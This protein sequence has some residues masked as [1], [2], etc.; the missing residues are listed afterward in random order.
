MAAVTQ[1]SIPPLIKTTALGLLGFWSI[2]LI[3]L[4]PRAWILMRLAQESQR[5]RRCA[6]SVPRYICEAGVAAVRAARHRESIAQGLQLPIFH[7]TGRR[8]QGFSYG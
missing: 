8:V 6:R 7:E 4:G 1:L 2:S 5:V 3:A